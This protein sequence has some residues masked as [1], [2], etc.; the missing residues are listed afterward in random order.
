MRFSGSKLEAM[1]E[2]R[3]HRSVVFT[4]ESALLHLWEVDAL[5]GAGVG[6]RLEKKD[7]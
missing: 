7:L 6:V 3:G 2:F 1:S 5:P 4:D